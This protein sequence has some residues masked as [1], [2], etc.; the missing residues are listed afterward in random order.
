MKITKKLLENTQIKTPSN[1]LQ[2][3]QEYSKNKKLVC[4][5][6]LQSNK[7]YCASFGKLNINIASTQVKRLAKLPS[8]LWVSELSISDV[9]CANKHKLGDVVIRAEATETEHLNW[10]S[11]EF[12]WFPGFARWGK[13]GP[14]E[15]WPIESHVNIIRKTDK[16]LLEW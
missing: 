9:Y 11:F 7:D 12:A 2:R 16:T 5:T 13:S 3:M 4:R 8:D 1:W 10:D 15:I 6:F 14:T